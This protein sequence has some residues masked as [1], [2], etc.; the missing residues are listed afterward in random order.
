MKSSL[1]SCC[2]G[3]VPKTVLGV[4][5]SL[6]G[7]QELPAAVC[8]SVV[9]FS[10]K[11]WSGRQREKCRGNQA[12][13]S[14]SPGTP[15]VPPATGCDDACDICL[16]GRSL[17]ARRRGPHGGLVHRHPLPGTYLNSSPPG[18]ERALGL[19]RAVCTRCGHNRP[20]SSVLGMLGSPQSSQ[21]PAEG[22]LAS[23]LS[24]G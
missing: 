13:A 4:A 14:R 9:Y 10:A 5:H 24:Q 23:R 12:E 6:G 11:T 20:L 7:P 2:A 16:R 3:G 22:H 15:L 1:E 19:D 18:G 21:T 8:A 17:D